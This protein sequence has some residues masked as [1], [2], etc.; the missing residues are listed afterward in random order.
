MDCK[1][2]VEESSSSLP[3]SQEGYTSLYSHLTRQNKAHAPPDHRRVR[4]LTP[5][6]AAFAQ[7]CLYLV[8]GEGEYR[9][10]GSYFC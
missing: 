2:A 4:I 1:A 6:L 9:W 8:E 3:V 5:H 10:L 7:Q